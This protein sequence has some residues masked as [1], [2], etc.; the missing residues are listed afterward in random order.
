MSSSSRDLAS[1]LTP[2]TASPRAQAS[3]PAQRSHLLTCHQAWPPERRKVSPLLSSLRES[4]ECPCWEWLFSGAICSL[5]EVQSLL[6]LQV[7]RVARRLSSGQR[8]QS[9]GGIRVHGYCPPRRLTFS[10]PAGSLGSA[11][12]MQEFGSSWVLGERGSGASQM[13]TEQWS[14]AGSRDKN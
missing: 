3:S 2:L 10:A 8:Q 12:R 13:L 11:D 6:M 4:R 5:A 1:L 14:S 9:L 7:H